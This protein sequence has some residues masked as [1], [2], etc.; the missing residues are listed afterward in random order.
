MF[1]I[2]RPDCGTMTNCQRARRRLR[3]T[4]LAEPIYALARR[5]RFSLDRGAGRP[6]W[7]RKQ[8]DINWADFAFGLRSM[9]RPT[10]GRDTGILPSGWIPTDEELVSLSVRTGWDLLL[11]ALGLPPGSEI[12]MSSVTIPDMARIVQHH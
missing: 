5:V 2:I 4:T 12:I 10:R 11:T 9:L 6:M 7:P 8:L 3:N 1:K